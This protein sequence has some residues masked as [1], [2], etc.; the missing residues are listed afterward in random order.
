MAHAGKKHIGRGTQ[1]K[2]DASGARSTLD[3]DRVGKNAVLSNRDK[4]Q[5]SKGRGLDSRNV[6]TEQYQDHI[7]NRR[8]DP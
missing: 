1:G 6:Q 3:D 2:G 4:A 5:H 8:I 7:G